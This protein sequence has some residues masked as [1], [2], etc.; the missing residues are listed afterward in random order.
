MS[1]AGDMSLLLKR[2][3]GR[4]IAVPVIGAPVRVIVRLAKGGRVSG[5]ND[6]SNVD[7]A[8]A[9]V[10]GLRDAHATLEARLSALEA[11]GVDPATARTLAL[12]QARLSHLEKAAPAR[13]EPASAQVRVTSDPAGGVRLE[14]ADGAQPGADAF[15]LALNGSAALAALD[16][17]LAG[18]LVRG[19][20][21][22]LA[23]RWARALSPGGAITIAV[24][25]LDAA[26]RAYLDRVI[27]AD[28]LAAA[29]AAARGAPDLDEV[30][31]ALIAAGWI[32]G[33]HDP[34]AH[35]AARVRAA[36]PIVEETH[37]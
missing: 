16:V 3:Y 14:A 2:I 34:T 17:D 7:L 1:L 32:G 12:I 21:A 24:P 31:S 35:G 22:E 13:A 19:R 6:T 30:R 27:D 28:A 8:V 9:A 10:A 23:K 36:A 11:D 25:D 29:V 20:M 5:V 4:V 37:G 18:A 33:A 15:A 26:A